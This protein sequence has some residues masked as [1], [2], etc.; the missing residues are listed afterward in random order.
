MFVRAAVLAT[1]L[2]TTAHAEPLPLREIEA[3]SGA[4]DRFYEVLAQVAAKK[5]GVVARVVNYGDSLTSNDSITGKLRENMQK[6]YGDGGAGW[7]PFALPA[8][9]FRHFTVKR[10]HKG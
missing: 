2:T 6:I 7:V 8:P 10:T 5:A 3:P 1:L 4:M 9:S